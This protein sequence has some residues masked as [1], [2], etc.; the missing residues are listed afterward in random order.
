VRAVSVL[1]PLNDTLHPVLMRPSTVLALAASL[2]FLARL[3]PQPLRTLRTRRVEGVSVLAAM[4]SCVADAAWLTYG[5]WAGLPAVW[6]VSVPA[7][8]LSGVTS[9]LLRRTITRRDL[10]TAVGWAL[11]VV[12]VAVVGLGALTLVL[13]GTVVVTCGPTLW[14][15][16]ASRSPVGL[17]AWTWWLAVADSSTWGTYGLLIGDAALEL[18]GVVMGATAAALLW[19]LWATRAVRP[20]GAVGAAA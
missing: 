16:Y 6:L 3:V 13:A 19:R 11:V 5:L 17:T 14:S 1:L 20:D 12:V 8:I 9:F 7:V 2:V 10:L 4:N 15:A 18:Y